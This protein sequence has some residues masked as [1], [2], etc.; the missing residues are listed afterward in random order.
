MADSNKQTDALLSS[1]F[2]SRPA[3]LL[4]NAQLSESKAREL[5]LQV[6]QY[7]RRMYQDARL[8]HADLSEFNMLYVFRTLVLILIIW[9]LCICKEYALV[10]NSVLEAEGNPTASEFTWDIAPLLTSISYSEIFQNQLRV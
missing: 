5:Y 4:K 10:C 1:S 3:P 6:I 2:H 8:V 9:I 7:M